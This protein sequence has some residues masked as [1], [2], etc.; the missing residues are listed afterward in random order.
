VRYDIYALSRAID[1]AGETPDAV[2]LIGNSRLLFGIIPSHYVYKTGFDAGFAAGA[3]FQID[4]NAGAHAAS[5]VEMICS[6]SSTKHAADP[7][8]EITGDRAI[9]K[10]NLLYVF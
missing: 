7:S 6:P 10:M 9:C 3:F 1:L 4:F 8:L 5:K 2:L